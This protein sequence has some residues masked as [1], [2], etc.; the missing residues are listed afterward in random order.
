[1]KKKRS[2]SVVEQVP[3]DKITVI[4]PRARNRKVFEGIVKNIGQLG[5]KRP[6]TVTRKSGPD[7]DSFDLVC[8]QG[9]LEAYRALGETKIQRWSSRR[10]RKT[11][12]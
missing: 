9:R 10:M 8:G 4:N 12:W 11:G 7:G 5:L 1:M 2:T 3:I 6:I